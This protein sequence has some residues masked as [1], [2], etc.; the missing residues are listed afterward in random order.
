MSLYQSTARPASGSDGIHAGD[1]S[2]RQHTPPP[3]TPCG[4]TWV[5]HLV[6]ALKEI[7]QASTCKGPES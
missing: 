5:C 6:I 7:V 4:D 3:P 1:Q 2:T